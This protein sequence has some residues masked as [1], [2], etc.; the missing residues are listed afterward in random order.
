[1]GNFLACETW[2]IQYLAEV[3]ESGFLPFFPP[4]FKIS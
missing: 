4:R 1:M 3:E 2:E